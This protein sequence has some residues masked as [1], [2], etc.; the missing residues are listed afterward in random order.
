MKYTAI[1]PSIFEKLSSVVTK[2]AGTT[3]TFIIAI[4]VILLWLM[5]GPIFNYSDTWQ[6]IINT[7]TTIITFLMVFLIQRSQNKESLAIQV[8]LNELIASSDKASN[9]LIDVEDLNEEEL[10]ALQSFYVELVK[11]SKKD[12]VLNQSHSVDE[13]IA[14]HERKTKGMKKSE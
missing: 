1:K 2:W 13:A 10:K 11:M 3:T 6:L 7:S 5:T 14:V 12:K 8:K 9:R 4:S